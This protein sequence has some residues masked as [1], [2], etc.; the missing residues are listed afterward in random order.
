M[1]YF[2][3]K[4][5][6]GKTPLIAHQPTDTVLGIFRITNLESKIGQI[7]YQLKGRSFSAL[8]P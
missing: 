2:D 8:L 6:V 3:V 4:N 5:K 7:S 1:L